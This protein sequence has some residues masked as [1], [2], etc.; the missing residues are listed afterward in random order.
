MPW[1]SREHKAPNPFRDNVPDPLREIGKSRECLFGEESFFITC[2]HLH[3]VLIG[4]NHDNRGLTFPI[5]SSKAQKFRATVDRPT[6]FNHRQ[7]ADLAGGFHHGIQA[8]RL[9]LECRADVDGH[10]GAQ[11]AGGI[12]GGRIC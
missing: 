10:C 8:D 7:R 9:G 12:G 5:C 3:P 4:G 1:Q 11:F 2:C 6:G